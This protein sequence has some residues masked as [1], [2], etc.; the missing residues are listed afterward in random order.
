MN[1]IDILGPNL[2]SR[3]CP[4][5]LCPACRRPGVNGWYD[6]RTDSW[7]ISCNKCGVEMEIPSVGTDLESACELLNRAERLGYEVDVANGRRKENE[8]IHIQG[9]AG[10]EAWKEDSGLLE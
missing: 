9:K 2:P 6:E 1:E 8:E 3:S 4:V 5:I 7:S 10:I